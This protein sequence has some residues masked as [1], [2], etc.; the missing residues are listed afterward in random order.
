MRQL[1]IRAID[2]NS[3]TAERSAFFNQINHRDPR[4]LTVKRMGWTRRSMVFRNVRN[5]R[6]VNFMTGKRPSLLRFSTTTLS[7]ITFSGRVR[8]EMEI[9][10]T[11]YEQEIKERAP[12]SQLYGR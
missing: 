5:V 3:I 7:I 11:R 12:L 1:E 10:V 2:A 9:V 6:N 8:E 4:L